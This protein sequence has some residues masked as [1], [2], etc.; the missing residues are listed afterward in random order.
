M[1]RRKCPNNKK[2]YLV[3]YQ[4]QKKYRNPEN[5]FIG[6]HGIEKLIHV[7]SPTNAFPGRTW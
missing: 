6:I 4:L 7:I 3:Q 2:Q 5:D 1:L